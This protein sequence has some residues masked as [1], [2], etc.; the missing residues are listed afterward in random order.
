MNWKH[1]PIVAF[2]TETTGLQPFAGDRIIEFAAVIFHTDM[3]GKV[4]SRDD[5]SWLINPGIEIPRKVTQITGISDADVIN[6]PP[7]EQVAND[8]RQLL[9][10]GITV[11]HNY[12]FDLA[13]LRNEFDRVD[14][15]WPNPIA[16]VDT[17][18]L[19][20]KH[21]SEAK[22]HRLAD[23]CKRLEVT[24]DGAHRATNDAA[25]C[26]ECF[27]HLA[28]RHEVPDQLQAM[29]DWSKAM[30]RPPE[31][32]PFSQNDSGLLIFKEPPFQGKY[33]IEHPIQLA[34]METAKTQRNGEW[35]FLYDENTRGWIRRWL[36]VRGAGR[37]RTSPKSFRAE[38][39]V[40]DSCITV[41]QQ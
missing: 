19:S 10:T 31:S 34:W 12:P 32:A 8:I 27:L 38:D 41:E 15:S 28:Q 37:A 5:H 33:I 25:A 23:L 26:G 1:L 11:A 21:F 29:L 6:A 3:N 35:T 2:D 40:L 18:D 14:L 20:I 39:W 16:E 24:L 7:F 22:H 17:Y 9:T 36:N 4:Q 13:F 30:G